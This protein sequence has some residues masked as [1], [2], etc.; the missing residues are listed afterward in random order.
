MRF[1]CRI[2]PVAPIAANREFLIRELPLPPR[3]RLATIRPTCRHRFR[4]DTLHSRGMQGG[5]HVTLSTHTMVVGVHLVVGRRLRR[6]PDG[7]EG[8]DYPTLT[9][10]GRL[11]TPVSAASR[12]RVC[13]RPRQ[14]GEGHVGGPSPAADESLGGPTCGASRPIAECDVAARPNPRG[15]RKHR[16]A[17]SGS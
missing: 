14:P 15:K 12:S 11:V 9:A 17:S 16:Q 5:C 13:V 8:T 7:E 3:G 6:Q 10:A 1:I 2:S 4:A